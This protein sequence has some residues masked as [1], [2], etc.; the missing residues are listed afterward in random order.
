MTEAKKRPRFSSASTRTHSR[1]SC[2]RRSDRS[3]T[4][5]CAIPALIGL[6]PL[7]AAPLRAQDAAVPVFR[8]TVDVR[9][10][11]VEVV[12]VDDDGNRVRGLLPS[13]FEVRIEGKPVPIAYFSEV[14]EGRVTAP[15]IDRAGE[16]EPALRAG[17]VVER[18]YL[19]FID[20]FFSLPADRDRIVRSL[21]DDLETLASAIGWRSPRGMATRSRS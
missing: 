7:L 16:V 9:V 5:L 11:N 2:W 14:A 6:L 10:V 13:D 8:D 18:S 12:V 17:E 20:E 21:I 4:P 1:A 15:S 3:R 19:V